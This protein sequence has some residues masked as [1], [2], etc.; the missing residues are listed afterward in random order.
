MPVYKNASYSGESITLQNANLRLDL[1]KR[2]TGWG[3]GEIFDTQGRCIAILDHLGEIMLRDQEI[4]MRLEAQDVVKSEDETG[5][6]L[7]FQVKS[8][9]VRRKLEGTSFSNWINY[10]LDQH[11]MVGE[12]TITL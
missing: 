9:I 3:W 1:H 11:I 5:T 2:R 4:P 6:S 12:V 8:L 10:P 7:V